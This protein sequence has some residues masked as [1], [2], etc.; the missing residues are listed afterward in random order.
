[1]AL[2]PNASILIAFWR[3]IENYG[4]TWSIP[5]YFNKDGVQ[6]VKSSKI[7]IDLKRVGRLTKTLNLSWQ[8]LLRRKN[9]RMKP[10][11]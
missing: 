9:T 10:I 3:Q 1:M 7:S 2:V 4:N 8:L 11:F 5:L 6:V